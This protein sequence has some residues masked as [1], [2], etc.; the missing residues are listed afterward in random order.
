MID[1]QNID[2]AEA[3]NVVSGLAVF[4]DNSVS[5]G[6]TRTPYEQDLRNKATELLR[7]LYEIEKANVRPHSG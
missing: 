6:R 5:E 1:L 4:M 3:I 2:V 7:K